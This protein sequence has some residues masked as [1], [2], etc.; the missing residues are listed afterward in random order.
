MD[1]QAIIEGL[2]HCANND[3]NGCPYDDSTVECLTKLLKDALALIEGEE[4]DE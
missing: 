3:C 1:K 2:R 4:E